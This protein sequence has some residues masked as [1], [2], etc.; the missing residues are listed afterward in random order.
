MFSW[1][2]GRNQKARKLFRYWDGLRTRNEDPLELQVRLETHPTCRWDTH[3]VLAEQGDLEAYRICLAAIRDVFGIPQF[4]STTSAGLTQLELME[5]LKSFAAYIEAL[6]KNTG[7]SP[8][9]RSSTDATFPR[10]SIEITRNSSG[11]P[12]T[13]PDAESF[14]QT[15]SAPV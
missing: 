3:P 12:S 9:W 10:S 6:K 14:T 4:D 15:Q 13:S 7:N 8:T 11:S 5:L 1:L 2:F